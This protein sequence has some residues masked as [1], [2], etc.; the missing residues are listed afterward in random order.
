MVGILIRTGLESRFSEPT[1][2]S[3]EWSSAILR[4]VIQS[5]CASVSAA[6]LRAGI[7]T[8]R[9]DP[10]LDGASQDWLDDALQFT[11]VDERDTAGVASFRTEIDWKVSAGFRMSK[12]FFGHPRGLSTCSSQRCGSAS[13]TTECGAILILFMT[14]TVAAA[15]SGSIWPMPV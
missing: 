8:D 15:D 2:E 14:A 5:S 13:A 11:V 7:H 3:K 10:T 12:E 6:F 9:G 4:K 1:P